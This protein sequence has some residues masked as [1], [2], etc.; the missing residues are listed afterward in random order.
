MRPRR[1]DIT[2]WNINNGGN[3]RVAIMSGANVNTTSYFSSFINIPRKSVY[4]LVWYGYD[5]LFVIAV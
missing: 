3:V 2:E 1:K 4:H 5:T